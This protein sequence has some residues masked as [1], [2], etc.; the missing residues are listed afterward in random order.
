MAAPKLPCSNCRG[1]K[2][3]PKCGRCQSRNIECIP[4]ERKAV[5]RHG[6]VSKEHDLHG[7]TFAADQTWVNSQPR[8]WRGSKSAAEG[9]QQGA[10][11]NPD[12]D[13]VGEGRTNVRARTEDSGLE[14]AI[15]SRGAADG[16]TSLT[17]LNWLVSAASPYSSI[18]SPASSLYQPLAPIEE[19]CLLRYFI[20]ELS[21][22]FDHCD[23]QSHFRQVVPLRA[24]TSRYP[25]LLNAI[26]AVSAR[27]LSRLPQYRTPEGNIK[28][29][30]QFLRDLSTSSAV[31]Y[32][33]KC[34]PGLSSFHDI[35]DP[36]EQENLMCAA[37]ILRQYEEM[38]EEMEETGTNPISF[39]TE[40]NVGAENA[41]EGDSPRQE[42]VN[43]L[44]ITQS[45]I[46][47]MI[48]SSSPLQ[49]SPLA[50]AAYWIAI[51][52]E[53]YYAL[54]RKRAP[55]L[56]FT[57]QDWESGT[58]ANKMI[59]HAG[60]VTRWCWG[61]RTLSE[62]ERL[63]HQQQQ[64]IITYSSQLTPILH[65]L[66]DRTNGEIFPTV[67]YATDAQVTGVQH[68]EMARMILIAE[69]PRLLE[70][71]VPRSMHR[72]TESVVRSI[73][74]NLCGIAVDVSRRMPA[75]V[76]AVIS[77]LLYGEYFTD[78]AERNAL[79]KIIEHMKD[80]RAWPLR[81]GVERLQRAWREADN[82]EALRLAALQRSPEAFTST[83]AREAQFDD[84]TWTSRVLN[85][86][87]TI[88]IALSPDITTENIGA[89]L[90]DDE[91][92][93][94][95]RAWLG[96]LTL[97]GPVFPIN[98]EKATRAPWELFKHIDFEQAARDAA[99]IP[100]GSNVVYILFGMYVLPEER[101]VGNGQ[102]LLEAG[103][104]TVH[105]E[106]MAKKVNATVII[107][108]ARENEKA[109]RLYERVGFL[110]WEE[111]V[112]IEGEAHWALSLTLAE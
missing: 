56:T 5:F 6:R 10:S 107:L 70:S 51:R 67:W 74:L 30:G 77:I 81:K 35:G 92:M 80:M 106:S 8:K 32:M 13:C 44:A 90:D 18:D 63:R 23:P 28:Y 50:V 100:D 62:Y 41:G 15:L 42:Q 99:F 82:V 105:K 97:M 26:F 78:L 103:I 68:L 48:S 109:K 75:L 72:K 34:I 73:V 101:G 54:T 7:N 86:L 36:T 58:V 55:C 69:N 76:N 17:R 47:T 88:F 79:L 12:Q 84:K 64:L 9:T 57:A 93:L 104:R 108:V 66:A 110:A 1:D 14:S 11:P 61:D 39:L 31:E 102:R 98:D 87:A 22:W 85:P 19:S 33:L 91:N 38:E 37:I 52:Q 83:Y 46:Q 24:Q 25:S 59:M 65:R 45:I 112:D 4:V 94:M 71:N 60:E 29:H 2:Q 53:V 3:K 16:H 89:R 95:K 20:E 49:R 96:Q 111:V 40:S 43:F 27:H 21:P